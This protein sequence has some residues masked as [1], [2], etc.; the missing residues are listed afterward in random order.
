[1]PQDKL[2]RNNLKKTLIKMRNAHVKRSLP[3]V[4]HEIQTKLDRC[5]TGID[6]IGPRTPNEAQLVLINQVATEYSKMAED[7][8]SGQYKIVNDKKLFTRM[9]I[10]S[11]LDEFYTSMGKDGVKIPFKTP[12]G[13]GSLVYPERATVWQKLDEEKVYVWIREAIKSY[14]GKEQSHEVNL[15]VKTLLWKEQMSS[16]EGIA[17][18]ALQS[19]Q[20]TLDLAHGRIFE[21]ACPDKILRIKLRLWVKH[22]LMKASEAAKEELQRLL[23]DEENS[24][25]FTFNPAREQKRQLLGDHRL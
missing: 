5:I 15:S 23:N 21:V 8:L 11:N 7:A 14:R 12:R 24:S 17:L 9:Y 13:V 18:S 20:T 10:R 2:G 25:F 19:V 3:N 4:L 1:M 16:W 6:Q 22:D